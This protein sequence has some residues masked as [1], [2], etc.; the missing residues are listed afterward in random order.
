MRISDWSSDVCSSDLEAGAHQLALFWR[1]EE[2]RVGE[3]GHAVEGVERE[4][5]LVVGAGHQCGGGVA[6]GDGQPD[7][8]RGVEVC[9]ERDDVEARCLLVEPGLEL[10]HRR[11]LRLQPLLLELGVAR[12][13]GGLQRSEERRV[14]KEGGRTCNSR[15]SQYP[16][17][18]THKK[19]PTTQ[20]ETRAHKI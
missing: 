17:K 11:T 20:T 13:V 14:G 16:S 5:R 18:K 15:W 1:E 3:V 8:G 10:R 19:L 6:G 7:G 12:R 4:R 9:E 2:Q